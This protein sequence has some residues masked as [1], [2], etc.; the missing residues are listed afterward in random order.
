MSGNDASQSTFDHSMKPLTDFISESSETLT[1]Q[2]KLYK[3]TRIGEAN[4]SNVKRQ[5]FDRFKNQLSCYH[6]QFGSVYSATDGDWLYYVKDGDDVD[7]YLIVEDKY[8][9]ERPFNADNAVG[10][11]PGD[12]Q[13]AVL[14]EAGER[15]GCPVYVRWW[16]KKEDAGIHLDSK[17][18]EVLVEQGVVDEDDLNAVVSVDKQDQIREEWFVRE[19]GS[20]AKARKL[21]DRV[22]H[23]DWLEEHRANSPLLEATND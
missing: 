14:A 15:I 10:V 19:L 21:R 18:V 9:K 3:A 17:T 22:D 1:D 6:W 2:E 4:E 7:I 8:V 23:M 20:K 16:T 12:K 5:K 11:L 13:R